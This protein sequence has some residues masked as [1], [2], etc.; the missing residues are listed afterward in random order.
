MG[1]LFKFFIY[2]NK[3]IKST[4]FVCKI[5]KIMISLSK[6]EKMDI[7]DKL[8]YLM[9]IDV[10]RYLNSNFAILE[11]NQQN[12][13]YNKYYNISIESYLKLKNRNLKNVIEIFSINNVYEELSMEDSLYLYEMY[14][15]FFDNYSNS[16]ILEKIN[17][18]KYNQSI[19]INYFEQD[20]VIIF[21]KYYDKMNFE[22][23][24]LMEFFIEKTNNENVKN[25]IKLL[26]KKHPN[27]NN[28][29]RTLIDY[30]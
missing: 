11:F 29:A 22:K 20:I 5:L 9:T 3:Y 26:I 7:F 25:I 15:S 17:K 28:I 18:Y 21:L 1:F 16:I 14:I 19:L 27:Y 4:P 13:E 6:K 24:C 2:L 23:L 8:Y 30:L 12:N 10:N